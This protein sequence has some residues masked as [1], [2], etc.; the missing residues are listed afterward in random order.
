MLPSLLTRNDIIQAPIVKIII[1]SIKLSIIKL[2][3]VTL[4]DNECLEM[5]SSFHMKMT[6]I[7][8]IIGSNILH[9]NNIK[10][11]LFKKKKF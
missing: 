4:A 7:R 3:H 10:K 9:R 2:N 6:S 8:E 11:F 1:S 5:Q